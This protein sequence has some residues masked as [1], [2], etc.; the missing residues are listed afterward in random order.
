[1]SEQPCD[2][3]AVDTLKAYRELKAKSDTAA[4]LNVDRSKAFVDAIDKLLLDGVITNH[5][6]IVGIVLGDGNLS[7]DE[8]EGYALAL[9]YIYERRQRHNLQAPVA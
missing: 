6:E 1:M 2:Q 5:D 8:Y 3:L 7:A 4:R 9:K